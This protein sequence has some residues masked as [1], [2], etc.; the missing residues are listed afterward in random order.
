[1]VQDPSMLVAP[2]TVATDLIVES[3]GGSESPYKEIEPTV[4]VVIKPRIDSLGPFS[5]G[6]NTGEH[7]AGFLLPWEWSSGTL[8]AGVGA[9]MILGKGVAEGAGIYFNPGIGKSTFDV[10]GC[11]EHSAGYGFDPSIGGT[12][13]YIK[14]SAENLR[15]SATCV[16]LGL[17]FG[18]VGGGVSTFNF[19]GAPIGGAVSFGV[20]GLQPFPGA[21]AAVVETSTR[22]FGRPEFSAS[23][24]A[25]L[26]L[27]F[28]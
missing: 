5:P 15:G 27:L 28:K 23:A 3:T 9:S 16:N 1:M 2:A 10:G 11:L 24:R 18:A 25:V 26:R 8:I 7:S 13:G 22:T 20:R 19:E 12:I 6:W 21:T 17:E 14:G 4:P